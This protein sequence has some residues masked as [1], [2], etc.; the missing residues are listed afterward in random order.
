MSYSLALIALSCGA[1]API[2]KATTPKIGSPERQ[3]ILNAFRPRIERDLDL[4]VKFEVHHMKVASGFA[5]VMAA[6]IHTNGKKIDWNKTKYA[7][8]WQ[9]GSLGASVLALLRKVKGK[10]S[11]L[12]YDF[13]ASD[14]PCEEWIRDHGAPRS[15]LP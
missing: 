10:W 6:P 9:E 13:G 3:A 15:L 8:R 1:L 5:F 4:K 7:R 2:Q 11:I 14:F 12:E